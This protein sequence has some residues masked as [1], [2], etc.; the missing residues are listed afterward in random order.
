MSER[1]RMSDRSRRRAVST[2][3]VAS[4]LF[5]ALAPPEARA[6]V[7]PWLLE[8]EGRSVQSE[9]AENAPGGLRRPNRHSIYA[10]YLR[11]YSELPKEALA[12]R[13]QMLR[14]AAAYSAEGDRRAESLLEEAVQ[15][16][17]RI[18]EAL[19]AAERAPSLEAGFEKLAPYAAFFAREGELRESLLDSKVVARL[20]RV[21]RNAEASGDFDRVERLRE[22]IR[23]SELG[24]A[25]GDLAAKLAAGIDRMAIY[26][27]WQRSLERRDALPGERFLFTSLLT[28]QGELLP[29]ELSVTGDTE[30]GL[31]DRLRE[32]L[33]RRLPV[34]VRTD[35]AALGTPI[36]LETRVDEI[37]AVVE[38][39]ERLRESVVLEGVD[40]K[41][42]P[43]FVELVAE[44]EEEVENYEDALKNYEARYEEYL[45]SREDSAS[46][47]YA[48]GD[49]ASAEE[50]FNDVMAAYDPTDDSGPSAQDVVAAEFRLDTA[51]YIN[52]SASSS[53]L[54]EPV[55]PAPLRKSELLQEIYKT[56]SVLV[57]HR[58]ETPYH[59][60]QQL[61]DVNFVAEANLRLDLPL[62][63]TSLHD[64]TVS[65]NRARRWTRNV[66]VDPRDASV[67]AGDFSPN[68]V[69][70]YSDLFLMEFS[71]LV[72]R[73]LGP[74]MAETGARLVASKAGEDSRWLGLALQFASDPLLTRP[75]PDPLARML[76]NA[77]NDPSIDDE[78]FRSLC[79]DAFAKALDG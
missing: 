13:I 36:G 45:R 27:R 46:Q 35:V 3:A 61:I 29:L 63:Q 47:T 41:P 72:A 22:E 53:E 20:R 12:E 18:G 37:D 65:L 75:L 42:N 10:A 32:D 74:F 34:N 60:T 49:L 1:E 57:S 14:R 6:E 11:R 4:G 64:E 58:E 15:L 5:L 56:P 30:E 48:E 31:D 73:R 77:A 79:W 78:R 25:L 19:A 62:A 2:F 51:R 16:R 50:N 23:R 40:E 26:R 44:Y 52:R 39:D 55:K 54:P 43:E 71:S 17:G 24:S 70:V 21:I 9:Q 67:E 59:Y 76:A 69:A 28:R 38:I 8:Q 66:D 68:T 7:D 33:Q